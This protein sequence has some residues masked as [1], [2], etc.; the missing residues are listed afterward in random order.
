[1]S[2]LKVDSSRRPPP[3]PATPSIERLPDSKTVTCA[4]PVAPADDDGDDRAQAAAERLGLQLESRA[5]RHRQVDA[6]RVRLELVA[7]VRRQRPGEGHRSR[8]RLHL[9]AP[10][11]HPA[12]RHLA[13]HRRRLQ[14]RRPDPV[15]VE[16]ATD[17]LGRHGVVAAHVDDPHTA[18]HRLHLDQRRQR[19]EPHVAA[20][21]FDARLARHVFDGDV[22]GHGL[23]GDARAAGHGHHV[24]HGHGSR[25]AAEQ[26]AQRPQEGAPPVPGL[27]FDPVTTLLDL[28]LDAVQR[29]GAAAADEPLRRPKRQVVAVHPRHRR[30]AAD[31]AEREQAAGLHRD[32]PYQF[33]RL[34]RGRPGRADQD[35][36]DECAPHCQSGHGLLPPVPPVH[37]CSI[38]EVLRVEDRH[39]REVRAPGP[40][41]SAAAQA[42]A[43]TRPGAGRG[44]LRFPVRTRPRNDSR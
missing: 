3:S 27:D 18:G 38:R 1:M 35:D 41:S 32:G 33:F 13:A 11:L 12:Q 40:R 34:P 23:D 8:H 5:L 37:L 6:A 29:L 28:D 21:H 17:R 30:I 2:P 9:D 4:G 42:C 22:A 14:P 31:V 26:V 36:S 24:V 7:P 39:G 25:A 19:S 20:H 16:A 15:D 44:P 10:R 43:P